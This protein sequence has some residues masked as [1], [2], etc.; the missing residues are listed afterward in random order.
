MSNS[1]KLATELSDWDIPKAELVIELTE[2][3]KPIEQLQAATANP[4]PFIGCGQ[5]RNPTYILSA[6]GKLSPPKNWTKKC[7]RERGVDSGQ[8]FVCPDCVARCGYRW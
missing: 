1:K 7:G 2:S 6:S 3:P 8:F 5:K 4:S